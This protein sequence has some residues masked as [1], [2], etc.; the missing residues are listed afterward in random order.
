MENTILTLPQV[1][2]IPKHYIGGGMYAREL[3]MPKDS[4]FT[5]KIHVKE[6]IV[7]LCGDVTVATD[8][9]VVRYTGYCAF[10]GKPGSI[11]SA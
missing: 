11:T 3:F 4:Y 9:E 6:H 8:E 5:G 10:V 7:I 1:E 2:A